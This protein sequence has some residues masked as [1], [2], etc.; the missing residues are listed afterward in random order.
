M[1]G[2]AKWV[3]AHL[4]HQGDLTRLMVDGVRP[5]TAELE[6]RELTTREF[7]VLRHWEGGPHIRLRVRPAGNPEDVE[8]AITDRMRAFFTAHPSSDVLTA[9]QYARIAEAMRR[10]DPVQGPVVPRHPTDSIAFVPYRPEFGRYGQGEA[11]AAVERHFVESSRLAVE[12]LARGLASGRENAAALSMLAVAWV[13]AEPD[14]DR[15]ARMGTVWRPRAVARRNGSRAPCPDGLQDHARA[16][17]VSAVRMVGNPERLTGPGAL[18]TWTRSITTLRDTLSCLDAKP[19]HVLRV[20][21]SCAHLICNR[22]GISISRES[23]LRE[24]LRHAVEQHATRQ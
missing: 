15:L 18:A 11:M 14:F 24:I 20:L 22:L 4:F 8:R 10:I 3:S 12:L 17:L 21:D 7:F 19:R 9:I 6:A 5:L 13:A 1:T 23:L 16:A 2:E